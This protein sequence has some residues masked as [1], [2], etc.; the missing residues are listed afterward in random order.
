M[1]LHEMT[2]DELASSGRTGADM[3]LMGRQTGAQIDSANAQ[4]ASAKYM[5]WSVI[6]ITGTSV[7]NAV[8]AF[9]SWYAPHMPH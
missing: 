9:L 3:E 7:V 1:Q 5:L 4:K 6:A 2:V 8:F